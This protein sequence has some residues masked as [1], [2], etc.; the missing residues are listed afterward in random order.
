[1]FTTYF[2][3]FQNNHVAFFFFALYSESF[4]GLKRTD[5]FLYIRKFTCNMKNI[6]CTWFAGF[7]LRKTYIF[8]YVLKPNLVD[9][10]YS[11]YLLVFKNCLKFFIYIKKNILS[12]EWFGGFY[13][14][15]RI[16]LCTYYLLLFI[17]NINDWFILCFVFKYVCWGYFEQALKD[18]ISKK[19]KL[20]VC[21]SLRQIYKGINIFISGSPFR[22]RYVTRIGFTYI[23]MLACVRACDILD[24][25]QLTP[26]THT[27]RKL[28]C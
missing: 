5:F 16:Y 19:F 15:E 3:I 18:M 7:L 17:I 22:R 24:I 25:F 26:H 11:D 6:L 28:T 8:V 1:M 27:M 23:W 2:V 13:W 12:T 14:E 10:V 4:I 9:L 21:I 20:N